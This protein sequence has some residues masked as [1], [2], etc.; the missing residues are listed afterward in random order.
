MLELPNSR[1]RGLRVEGAR[2]W[3][4]LREGGLV[5]SRLVLSLPPGRPDQDEVP[6][7]DRWIFQGSSVR[8]GSDDEMVV[9]G[10]LRLG[11]RVDPLTLVVLPT[12]YHRRGGTEYLDLDVSASLPSGRCHASRVEGRL[13]IVRATSA[14]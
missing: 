13:R 7:P 8:R 10:L 12:R 4:E 3:V 14:A 2:G 9:A 5:G 6:V 11:D 1:F